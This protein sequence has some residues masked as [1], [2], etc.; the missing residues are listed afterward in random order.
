MLQAQSSASCCYSAQQLADKV[1]FTAPT[2]HRVQL[3]RDL[4]CLEQ[5]HGQSVRCCQVTGKWNLTTHGTL[6]HCDGLMRR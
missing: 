5:G 2:A 4:P 6:L 3:L 1:Q